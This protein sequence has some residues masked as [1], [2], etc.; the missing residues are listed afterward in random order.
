MKIF[1]INV[2][3]LLSLGMSASAYSEEPNILRFKELESQMSSDPMLSSGENFMEIHTPQSQL[4]DARLALEH[5]I[6]NGTSRAAAELILR[7]AGAHC[8]SPKGTTEI[9]HY[10]DIQTPRSDIDSVEWQ[11]SLQLADEQVTNFSVE[12]IWVRKQ[13]ND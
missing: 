2:A 1:L 6:P 5:A 7:K 8:R 3:S 12:R 10:Y 4:A 9:C 11:V 13:T